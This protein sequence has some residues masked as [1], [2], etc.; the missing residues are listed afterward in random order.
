MN[1]FNSTEKYGELIGRKGI[2]FYRGVILGASGFGG[3][4]SDWQST[5]N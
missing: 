1:R 5:E 4:E 2:L 3:T